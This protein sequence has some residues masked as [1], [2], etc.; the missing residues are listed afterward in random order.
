M[1]TN[2]NPDVLTCLAN[3]SNDEVFTPPELVNQM[4]DMLPA[5]LWLNKKA[6][7]LDPVTKSGV[8]LREIAKRLNKGLEQQIPDVQTRLN[9]IFTQQIYGIAITELTSLLARRSVYCA[10]QAN[11]D[12]SICTDFNDTQGNIRYTRQQHTWINGK[13]KFCG[14]SQAVYA[15]DGELETHAY[16]FIHTDDPTTLF[17]KNMKFDV[18]IGNPPYQLDTD[19]FGGQA[20]PI[21]N[22]FVAQAKKLN[23]KYLCMIIPS[24]W[25][26]GGMGLNEFRNS[27]LTDKRMKTIVDMTDASDCFPGVEIK[28]GVCYFLR[29]IQHDGLCTVKTII[30]NEVLDEQTRDLSEFDILVRFN[31]AVSILKKVTKH[32]EVFCNSMAFG[33]NVFGM[34]TNFKD[35]EKKHSTSNLLVFA[36]NKTEELRPEKLK[37]GTELIS[38][39][40]VLLSKAYNAGDSYP[41]QVIGKPIVA[42]PNSCCTMTYFVSASFESQNEAKNYANYLATKFCRFMISIR[43]N[44][45]DINK[46]KL[47]FVPIQDFTQSWTDEKLYAKYNLTHDE[48]AFIE[49]MIRP[50]ELSHE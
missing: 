25:F 20:K 41:H 35:F 19:G 6:K 17:G 39:Y 24:R 1:L 38:K 26:A 5:E 21:Y 29:D 27:M 23:P 2:Y 44:T 7:F 16:N 31:K 32:S 46:E 11:G 3:L 50:M 22:L 4:L 37:Q 28:S 42:K 8:F 30:K 49:S 45:Q 40:K 9:H 14:A 34:A 48:I 10:K 33:L 36:R 47:S 13:C 15:R 43:K 18:I 12:R